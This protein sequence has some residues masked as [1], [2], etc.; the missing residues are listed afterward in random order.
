MVISRS[1][2]KHM[3]CASDREVEELLVVQ[4]LQPAA[5][6]ITSPLLV[7]KKMKCFIAKSD[8]CV[9]WVGEIST[10]VCLAFHF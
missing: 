3:I 8:Y 7:V 5:N 10:S 2:N 4:L 9:F 1:N 6:I